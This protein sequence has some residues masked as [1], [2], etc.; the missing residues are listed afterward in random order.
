MT[1]FSSTLVQ[2]TA[3]TNQN[4]Y[5]IYARLVRGVGGGYQNLQ[6]PDLKLICWLVNP[7]N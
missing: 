7:K 4:V 3:V 6:T 5:C 1:P 2:M